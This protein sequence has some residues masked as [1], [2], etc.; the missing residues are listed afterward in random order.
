[1]EYKKYYNWGRNL[2]IN[3]DTYLQYIEYI[4]QENENNLK[5]DTQKDYLHKIKQFLTYF[6]KP[7]LKVTM[8]DIENYI[9]NLK[10]DSYKNSN[11]YALISFI[12]FVEITYRLSFSSEDLK[13]LIISQKDINKSNTEE[14]LDFD[15]IIKLRALLGGNSKYIKH[16]YIFELVYAYGLSFPELLACNKLNYNYS[17]SSFTI[18]ERRIYVNK[19]ISKLINEND[20]VLEAKSKSLYQKYF[21]DMGVLLKRNLGLEFKDVKATY[22]LHSMKCPICQR[23]FLC[24]SENWHLV[25]HKKDMQETKWIVCIECA[26]KL[27]EQSED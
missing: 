25:N 18:G 26:V 9:S 7:I 1:M 17:N 8:L 19:R 3:S 5:E 11:L 22:A 13:A 14:P 4:S 16:Y 12:S 15:D 6:T 2:G 21:N 24:E 10:S 27:G 20:N 23:S